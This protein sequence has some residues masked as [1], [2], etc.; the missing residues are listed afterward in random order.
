MRWWRAVRFPSR[1]H[2][3]RRHEESDVLSVMIIHPITLYLCDRLKSFQRILE[4][5]A[6]CK[7][8]KL[9]DVANFSDTPTPFSEEVKS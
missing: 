6:S 2:L 4:F 8:V 7:T 1:L 9:G 3:N 5:L